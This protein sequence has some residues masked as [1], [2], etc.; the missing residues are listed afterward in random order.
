MKTFLTATIL[1]T[2]LSAFLITTLQAADEPGKAASL[3]IGN[4]LKDGT[5][6]P[7]TSALAERAA[8]SFGQGKWDDARKA[9][10]EI[11]KE[12]PNN[13]LTLANLGAVEQGAGRMNEAQDYLQRAVAI[14]PSLLQSWIALG[15]VSYEKGDTYLALSA[16][17]RA[18]H[19]DPTDAKAHNYLAVIVK[20]LGWLDAAEAELQRAI[21]LKSDYANA[22]FNLALMY[23]ERKPP[24]LELAKRHYDKAV[25]LGAEKDEV[26]ERSLSD[27]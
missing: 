1:F 7:L 3:G 12:D 25:S 5:L 13:A 27:K 18:T 19:E 9:Y 8:R 21:A 4:S 26:V 14:N 23:L 15:M 24:A 16:L 11:L 2:H 22:H 10:E 6:P 20:K 17:S